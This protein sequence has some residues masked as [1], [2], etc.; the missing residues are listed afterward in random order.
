LQAKKLEQIMRPGYHSKSNSQDNILG[1][2]STPHHPL[3]TSTSLADLMQSDVLKFSNAGNMPKNATSQQYM[4]NLPRASLLET[5][6]MM[7]SARTE[8]IKMTNGKRIL[9]GGLLDALGNTGSRT[10]SGFRG[11]MFNNGF[12]SVDM[13]ALTPSP[14]D[15][16]MGMVGHQGGPVVG[17][18]PY[19]AFA[20][21][22][23]NLHGGMNMPMG[24]GSTPN[25]MNMNMMGMQSSMNLSTMCM[26]NGLGAGM[27]A[28]M[29]A[30]M[31]MHMGMNPAM[32]MSMNGLNQL[33]S[34]AVFPN[35]Q[36]SYIPG[37]TGVNSG[38]N[39]FGH[40]PQLNSTPSQ[41][42]APTLDMFPQRQSSYIP[43]ITGVN[44]GLNNFGHGPRL[45]ATAPQTQAPGLEL[46]LDAKGRERI[47]AW[48]Q[49][50]GEGEE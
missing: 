4:A 8:Q 25:L 18:S 34:A 19:G 3:R 42:H 20:G 50:I 16:G 23:P 22:S 1:R 9:S 43:G 47:D 13:Q 36:S 48:R 29:G 35:R 2:A 49:N 37:I 38:L 30:G 14:M 10:S 17:M 44:S 7:R 39:N 32:N 27:D 46:F 11:G 28:G 24:M 45:N 33:P 40:G 41:T 5:N 6:D 15:M 21:S 31:G 12:G 26:G